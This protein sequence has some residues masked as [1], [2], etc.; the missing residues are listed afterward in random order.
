MS[1]LHLPLGVPADA[2]DVEFLVTESNARAAHQLDRWGM[3]P[4]MAALLVGPPKSGRSLLARIFVERTG[5]TA[6]DN[7]ES[8]SEEA[9]FHAWNEAQ[10]T[11]SP[12]LIVADAPPPAWEVAL[13]DLRSRLAASPVLRIDPPDDMLM[14]L[15]LERTLDR[16]ALV[17]RPEVIAWLL[18][19]IERSHLALA[20]VGEELEAEAPRLQNRRLSIQGARATLESAGLLFEPPSTQ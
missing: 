15:L 12:L 6:I 18:A 19:R 5:G 9:L 14:R 16:L 3:W 1:Q 2:R 17:T 20:R 10:I 13:P 8:A 7:A 11:R 4:V